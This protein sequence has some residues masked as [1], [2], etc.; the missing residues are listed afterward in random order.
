MKSGDRILEIDGKSVLA[1]R[2][3]MMHYVSASTDWTRSTDT[4][5][6][7]FDSYTDT[8]PKLYI[9]AWRFS[10]PPHSACTGISESYQKKRISQIDA[11]IRLF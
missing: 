3:S 9:D 11:I 8:L 5:S 1:W 10:L 4:A 6:F 7:V 2:D